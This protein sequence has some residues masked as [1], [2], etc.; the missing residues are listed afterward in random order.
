MTENPYEPPRYE[1][2][3]PSALP[4]VD[5]RRTL[6][7]G[8]ALLLTPVAA[9]IVYVIGACL[10]HAA[11][12]DTAFGWVMLVILLPIVPAFIFVRAIANYLS[13]PLWWDTTVIAM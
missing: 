12:I 3:P 13:T 10:F 11:G 1:E 9:S 7:L 6:Q 4:R 8:V 2:V 5:W